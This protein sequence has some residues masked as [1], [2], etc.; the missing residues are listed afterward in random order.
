MK[1]EII[2]ILKDEEQNLIDCLESNKRNFTA[3][4]QA[5]VDGENY[6]SSMISESRTLTIK[7]AQLEKI[8][9]MILRIEREVQK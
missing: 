9:Q 5:K 3:F 6:A 7:M 8:R 4:L 1:N 2:K